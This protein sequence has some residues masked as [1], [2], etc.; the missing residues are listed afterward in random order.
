MCLGLIACVMMF[1]FVF[2]ARSDIQF[3]LNGEKIDARIVAPPT[4]V[5]NKFST[6]YSYPVEYQ[7]ADGNNRLAAGLIRDAALKTG[8]IIPMRY[9]RRDP[10]RARSEDGLQR[11]WPT[12]IL[13]VIAVFISIASIWYGIRGTREILA[14]P[15]EH[16][17]DGLNGLP[18]MAEPSVQR[19]RA[20]E[21]VVKS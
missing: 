8:D 18:G 14:Q 5:R 1:P 21:R 6:C 12:I 11:S 16:A 10:A 2:F 9:L 3:M 20:N 15:S 7:D 17:I 4:V 13:A 19:E